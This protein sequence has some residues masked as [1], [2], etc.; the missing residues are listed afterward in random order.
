VGGL[1]VEGWG[2]FFDLM[3]GFIFCGG[4][5]ESWGGWAVGFVWGWSEVFVVWGGSGGDV[6]LHRR[7]GSPAPS[8]LQPPP[9]FTAEALARTRHRENVTGEGNTTSAKQ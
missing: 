1:F 6:P 2:W 8:L 3:G 7:L 9:I 4:G 5:E